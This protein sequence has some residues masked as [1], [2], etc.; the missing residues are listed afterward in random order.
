MTIILKTSDLIKN[1]T[2]H[3]KNSMNNK[4][5]EYKNNIQIKAV[6]IDHIFR[7]KRPQTLKKG[8]NEKLHSLKK[9]FI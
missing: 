1:I 4:I 6:I 2:A 7:L 5:E 9:K 3:L 8:I